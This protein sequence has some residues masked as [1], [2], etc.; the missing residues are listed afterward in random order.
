VKPEVVVDV[1][2]SRIK[3]GRC[4]ADRVTE[5]ASLPH[6]DEAAWDMQLANWRLATGSAW[7][8]SG[9][10]PEQRDRVRVWLQQRSQ[11]PHVLDSFRQL[12]LAM[13][14]DEPGK[15]G[16]DRLLNA[17]AVNTARAAGAAAIIVDAGS[18]ITVDYVDEAGVFRG[19]AILPGLRL[20]A[21]A[22]HDYTAKLPWIDQ[23]GAVALPAKNTEDAMRAGIV[24][25]AAGAID[26][27]VQQLLATS[28]GA[29]ELFIGGG[30]AILLAPRLSHSARLWLEMTLEG[31]RK[32][33]AA[34]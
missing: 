17:V 23:F 21:H 5:M 25:A 34:S 30:D 27:A 6:D 28:S 3:W 9:T 18:A 4:P 16:L 11:K 13:D 12:P 33:V 29:V 8:L 14:V 15:V 20:M 32:S 7:A 2:N 31:I 10:Q 1:G 19:G 22:L 26:S 24:Y